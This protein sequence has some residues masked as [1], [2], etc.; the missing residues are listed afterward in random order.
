[1]LA[2]GKLLDDLDGYPSENEED[3]H[4]IHMTTPMEENLNKP[5][6]AGNDGSTSFTELPVNND[7]GDA[8]SSK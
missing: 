1:M 4:N 5:F 8:S 3:P 2:L 6:K 7:I